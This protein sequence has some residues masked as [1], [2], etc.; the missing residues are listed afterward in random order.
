MPIVTKEQAIKLRDALVS[1][2]LNPNQTARARAHLE[3]FKWA[4]Q[5][6]DTT[7]VPA[8]KRSRIVRIGRERFVEEDTSPLDPASP[9]GQLDAERR[10]GIS[11]EGLGFSTRLKLALSLDDEDVRTDII[12]KAAE[13]IG[14][15]EEGELPPGVD[16]IY[17]SPVTGDMVILLKDKKTGKYRQHR[18]DGLGPE[19]A[20][21]ADMADPSEVGSIVGG[22]IGAIA[23]VRTGKPLKGEVA[24]EAAGR[25]VGVF[26]E[27]IAS[28]YFGADVT[29]D[30]VEEVLIDNLGEGAMSVLMSRGF[31]K[32]LN[33]GRQ[34]VQ[35]VKGGSRG[36]TFEG[37]AA[38]LADA[39]EASAKDLEAIRAGGGDVKLTAG[40]ATGDVVR[41]QEEAGRINLALTNL[42]RANDRRI[43]EN[44]EGLQRFVDRSLGGANRVDI[45][46]TT[47]TYKA[48]IKEHNDMLAEKVEKAGT[49]QTWKDWTIHNDGTRVPVINYTIPGK[50]ADDEGLKTVIAPMEDGRI[51]QMVR[52]SQLH[53]QNRGLGGGLYRRM[54]EDAFREGRIPASDSKISISALRAWASLEREGHKFLIG[55]QDR[56]IPELLDLQT[57]KLTAAGEE[58]FNTNK[59]GTAFELKSDPEAPVLVWDT[60]PADTKANFLETTSHRM[61]QSSLE[62]GLAEIQSKFHR[63]NAEYEAS[64][65]AHDNLLGWNPDRQIS[66]YFIQNTPGSR[67]SGDMRRLQMISQRALGRGDAREADKML[68]DLFRNTG[69]ED[70]LTASFADPSLDVRQLI[71]TMDRLNEIGKKGSPE[72]ARVAGSIRSLLDNAKWRARDNSR[73]DTGPAKAQ[74]QDAYGEMR[75]KEMATQRN[76]ATLMTNRFFAEGYDGSYSN[77]SVSSLQKILKNG[78]GGVDSMKQAIDENVFLKHEFRK[79][80]VE[81]WRKQAMPNGT[82]N[83]N[84]HERFLQQYSDAIDEAWSPE[85]RA[86]I[87]RAP[88]RLG[89]VQS[90]SAQRMEKLRRTMAKAAG[91]EAKELKLNPT[92]MN[93]TGIWKSLR[94]LSPA[95][96]RQVMGTL[97]AAGGQEAV[98]QMNDVAQREVANTARSLIGKGD[99]GKFMEWVDMQETVLADQFGKPYVDNLRLVGRMLERTNKGVKGISPD[100][101]PLH[102]RVF[103]SVLGPLSKKQRFIT[104]VNFTKHRVLANNALRILADP[105]AMREFKLIAPKNGRWTAPTVAMATRL[106]LFDGVPLSEDIEQRLLE[107]QELFYD[108]EAEMPEGVLDENPKQRAVVSQRPQNEEPPEPV[109]PGRGSITDRREA[110]IAAS[111]ADLRDFGP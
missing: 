21:L 50:L 7:P 15:P 6:I 2:Q 64:L 94:K 28:R 17:P 16:L 27:T 86:Q 11:N 26:L 55:G 103:R 24:G 1:G 18:V 95:D 66:R 89:Q 43:M 85:F 74:W 105:Q 49:V 76:G 36:T 39:L 67:L 106:G 82:F 72:A 57:G 45:A 80:L 32:G 33:L 84:G 104:A 46:R 111:E 100:P 61:D 58:M 40:E 63:D 71:F 69:A 97:R 65:L 51:M 52:G 8:P 77:T 59:A 38:D 5:N 88:Q 108:L 35:S 48:A 22:V 42:R 81:V 87:N 14:L 101:Q 54:F 93:Y 10:M 70:D 90:Q 23:G 19:F 20:D 98:D 44:T 3:A 99:P 73:M 41:L 56:T 96:R 60:G 102:L 79:G 9:E 83:R 91:I 31:E 62:D 92:L 4:G 47:D 107:V 30:D 75:R 53:E 34:I 109:L 13:D 29:A 37:G 25:A 12:Q 110:S 68:A 78:S